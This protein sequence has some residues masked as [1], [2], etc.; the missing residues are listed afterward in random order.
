MLH[1]TKRVFQSSLLAALLA[2]AFA[3]PA[4]AF[5][6]A[7]AAAQ[8]KE[9]PPFHEYKGVRIGMTAD[10]ARKKLGDPTDKGDTQDFY[11]VGENET[12]QVF[13]DAQKKVHALSIIYMGGAS[14]PTA[15]SVI[16]ADVEAKPDG[17]MHRRVDYPKAG[18]WVAYS[19][20]AG[21]SPLVTITMQKK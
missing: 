13:Y 11:A 17:S 16:G 2:F 12:V 19:R 10:E 15:K 8:E 4:A 14:M 9:E 5:Q 18:F 1:T 3:L 7:G 6:N 20:T 21:D